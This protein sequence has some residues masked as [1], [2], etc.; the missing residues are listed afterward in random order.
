MFLYVGLFGVIIVVFFLIENWLKMLLL[1]VVFGNNGKKVVFCKLGW[2]LLFDFW[3][4]DLLEIL[5]WVLIFIFFD[6]K[7]F[8]EEEIFMYCLRVFVLYL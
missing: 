1:L 2:S 4:E 6:D 8:I 7:I 3:M 5:V